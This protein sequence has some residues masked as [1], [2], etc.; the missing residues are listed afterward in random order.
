MYHYEIEDES[1]EGID[2][3]EGFETLA[4]ATVAA[5]EAFDANGQAARWT[6]RTEDDT[7]VVEGTD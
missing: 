2:G 5:E 4:E 6:V 1:G 3:E 7:V